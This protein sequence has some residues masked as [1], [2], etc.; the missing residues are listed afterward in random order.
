MAVMNMMNQLFQLFFRA[1]RSEVGD[2]RFET[3]HQVSGGVHN[4]AAKSQDRIRLI[5]QVYGETRRIRIQA[6]AQ[7]TVTALPALGQ[8]G[9]EMHGEIPSGSPRMIRH[10]RAPYEGATRP[11]IIRSSDAGQSR[12]KIFI[13]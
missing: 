11:S 10:P 7:Q 13:A 5:A 4:L 12:P 3:A 9:H 6:D 8:G 1:H 2:L